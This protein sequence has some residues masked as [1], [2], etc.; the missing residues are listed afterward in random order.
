MAGNVLTFKAAPSARDYTVTVTAPGGDF[1]TGNSRTLTVTVTADADDPDRPFITTWETTTANEEI[2][3]PGTGT[4][5]VVWGDGE[6]DNDASGSATHT[7]AE[8]G[9][10]TVSITG[11]LER[12][13][14]GANATNAQ[15]L[16]SIEQWGNTKW[17]SMNNAFRGASD[18][19]YA[20]TDAPDLSKVTDMSNM[21]YGATSFDGDLSGWDVSRVTN[22]N[23]MFISAASFD[24]NLSGWDV[25][26]VTGMTSMFD[27]AT[28]FNGDLSSWDV[29]QV[30][31]MATMFNNAASFNQD[32][33]GWNVSQ[34]TTMGGM[35][36][37]AADFQPGHLRMERLAGD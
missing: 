27:G 25:S 2:T 3:I 22:M 24:G 31:D 19:T 34:V 36:W 5:D 21:F 1:G 23:S 26:K 8:P 17:A 33:S 14:L 10:Y 37:A 20:A 6:F 12:I 35:F 32:I 16:Q 29:S 13:N 15:K 9:T 7:Y 18:V 4:Y 28:A 30:T 11:G